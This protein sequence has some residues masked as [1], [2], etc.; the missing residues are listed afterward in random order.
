M[1]FVMIFISSIVNARTNTGSASKVNISARTGRSA[2]A[3]LMFGQPNIKAASVTCG[4]RPGGGRGG[5]GH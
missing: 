4:A 5:G 1:L 2:D 3:A